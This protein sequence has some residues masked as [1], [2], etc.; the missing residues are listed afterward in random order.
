M[1]S[2]VDLHQHLWPEPLVDRLRARA[3]APFLRGWTLH[4]RGEAPYDVTPGDHD[5]TARTSADEAAGVGLACVS[6]SAPLG[7]EYL[8]RPEAGALLDVWHES[9]RDLPEHFRAWASVPVVD[10][11]LDDLAG[12]LA[13]DVFVGL[14]VPATDLASPAAWERAGSVLRVAERAG[15][16]VFVHPGPEVTRPLTGSLPSWWAPVVGYATQMQTAWW[17]WHAAGGRELFPRLR[18][19]FGAGAGLA[20]VHQERHLARGGVAT[21]VD[22]DV[23]V[24][25]SSYGPQ[26]L[27]ALVR[28]LGIDALALGSDRPYGL[29]VD[30]LLGE[31]ATYAVREANPRRVLTGHDTPLTLPVPEREV[32]TWRRAS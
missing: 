16:P 17:G 20:P 2:A 4:T 10:P 25:T 32:P 24:D 28:V 31:A 30:R 8:V 23:Y 13:E 14:Q 6:L 3:R 29:P 27:D 7:V 22:P 1:P 18:V 26:A 11:D 19:L 5:A 15:K 9:V 21:T 12:L